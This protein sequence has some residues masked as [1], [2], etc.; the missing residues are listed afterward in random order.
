MTETIHDN[1]EHHRFD[2]DLGDGV[3]GF[4][5]YRLAPGVITLTHSEVPAGA[6]GRGFGARLVRTVLTE[7]RGRGLRVVP[8]CGYVAHF[9]ADHSEFADLTATPEA[10]AEAR[11]K[12]HAHLDARLD[13]ALKETFPASDPIAVSYE[14]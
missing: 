14:R 12:A 8:A 11:K 10:A 5:S 7:L 6:R 13:E 3:Q 9:I 1:T 4:V 2:V